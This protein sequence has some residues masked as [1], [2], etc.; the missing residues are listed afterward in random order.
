MKAGTAPEGAS[1][2]TI[3]V[4]RDSGHTFTEPAALA[5]PHEAAADPLA[6]LIA[7]RWPA[8][9]CPQHRAAGLPDPRR[10]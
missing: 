7:S 6:E 10:P 9:Q 8:C 3:R 1:V 4:S 5:A 2:I